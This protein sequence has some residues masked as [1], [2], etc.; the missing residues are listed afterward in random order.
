MINFS[1]KGQHRKGKKTKDG[2]R[3]YIIKKWKSQNNNEIR[4]EILI[5]NQNAED[6]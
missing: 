6:M 4:I 2:Y 5:G 3:V 1:G